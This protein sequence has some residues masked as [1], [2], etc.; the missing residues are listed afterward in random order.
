MDKYT[1]LMINKIKRDRELGI[2]DI[3]EHGC[4]MYNLVEIDGRLLRM[5]IDFDNPN[6]P[7]IILKAP[8]PEQFWALP[9]YVEDEKEK[10]NNRKEDI[11]EFSKIAEDFVNKY[12]CPHTTI[13]IT[14]V[15]IDISDS[16]M[17]KSFVLRD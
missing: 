12:G 8:L 11:E 9:I 16:R 13:I 2:R 1:E 4:G 7:N 17:G 10:E 5:I 6:D 15:G 14:Q 3:P